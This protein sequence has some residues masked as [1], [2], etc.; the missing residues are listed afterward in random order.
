MSKA[1]CEAHNAVVPVQIDATKDEN[2]AVRN[3]MGTG[4]FRLTLREP[5]RR[6]IVEKNPG[7]WDKP[8]FN[9]IA[10][11]RRHRLRR[12]PASPGCSPASST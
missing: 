3:A 6:T 1:W 12:R 11:I 5:D 10:S 2:F 4:P 9:S 8:M 7:W